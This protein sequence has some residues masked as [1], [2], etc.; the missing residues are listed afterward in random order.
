MIQAFP[1]GK[2]FVPIRRVT[3]DGERVKLHKIPGSGVLILCR[4]VCAPFAL[5]KF[6]VARSPEQAF[7][8]AF[9]VIQLRGQKGCSAR[10]ANGPSGGDQCCAGSRPPPAV[11]AERKGPAR[12]P[13]GGG[14]A[15]VARACAGQVGR[16]FQLDYLPAV[17]EAGGRRR[18][19][20]QDLP[21]RSI[22]E[23]GR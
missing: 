2:W 19:F 17:H 21:G 15:P 10:F 18:S 20:S 5:A 23:L 6:F 1:F 8:P 9:E 16:R 22:S 14:L 7:E 12:G 13:G 11:P 4:R 3:G